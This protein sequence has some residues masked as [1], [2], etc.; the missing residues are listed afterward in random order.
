[1]S[2]DTPVS[3]AAAVHG[4]QVRSSSGAAIGTLEHV[5]EVPELDIFDGIVIHTHVGLR[6]IEA[7]HVIQITRSHL[8]T[9]LD[10]SQAAALPAP[11]GPPVYHVECSRT[12]ATTCTTCSA[13]SSAVRTGP[14]TTTSRPLA[15]AGHGRGGTRE[16][17]WP[18]P[19]RPVR[20]TTPAAAAAT[21]ARPTETIAAAT[22][23]FAAT[24]PAPPRHTSPAS[25]LRRR[26]RAPLRRGSSYRTRPASRPAMTPN[27]LSFS[28]YVMPVSEVLAENTDYT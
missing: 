20:S 16:R 13:A 11:D 28:A 7:D 21:V 18:P 15:R 1:M 12:A 3:Y 19:A 10:D 8:Q 26:Q 25:P 14:A 9:D 6:F 22:E 5:L 23:A 17:A 24:E 27:F 4:S 2:D